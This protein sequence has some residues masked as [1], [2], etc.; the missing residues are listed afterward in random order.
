MQRIIFA[1]NYSQWGGAQIYFLALIKEAR[2]YFEPIVILP[3]DTD[4]NFISL[5][6][7]ENIRYEEFSGSLDIAPKSGIFQKLERQITR[8][9]SE[10]AMLKKISEIGL[11][12]ALVHTDISPGQ[13]LFSLVWLS[14]RTHVFITHHNAQPTVPKW[15][16]AAW[17][18]K[19]GIISQFKTFHA[20]AANQHSA[21]YYRQL[22]QKR[23]AD[24]LIVTYASID[25][26][27]IDLAISAECEREKTLKKFGIR[28]PL[29][30]L[31]VGQFVDR[32]GRWTLLE[33]AKRVIEKRDDVTFIWVSPTK[34]S[35][36]EMRRIAEFGLGDSFK[37]I[38]S[39]DI[40]DHRS[41]LKF[42]RIAHVFVLPSYI[43]GL[44]IALLE[45]MAIGIPSISTSI[46]GIPEAIIPEQTG[47]L[48]KPGDPAELERSIIRL[49][50]EP[51]LRNNLSD[52]GKR[53]VRKMFDE[54][55]MAKT[56]VREYLAAA[57]SLNKN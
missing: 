39:S 14:L 43:E 38:R 26:A 55:A 12:N 51:D 23:T 20:F 2:K 49:L 10:Y 46:N 32:K 53:H 48:I 28:T 13:S 3:Q 41:V 11:E 31:T 40:G 33:S 16:R 8:A 50:S 22:Y 6:R 29:V 44:P 4:Q 27:E 45:A 19:Y 7:S 34:P 15:R 52:E 1:W 24:D 30:I 9:K 57:A 5:L 47:L 36:D 17:T 54:R 21:K 56:A 37:L 25:P 35:Y 18:V 42:F